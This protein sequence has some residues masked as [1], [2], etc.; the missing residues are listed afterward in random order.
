MKPVLATELDPR[1]RFAVT[2][3]PLL[4]EVGAGLFRSFVLTTGSCFLPSSIDILPS[5]ISNPA[6]T[7][8]TVPCRSFDTTLLV[9]LQPKTPTSSFT[10]QSHHVHKNQNL[11]LGVH[12]WSE[13]S[14]LRTLRRRIALCLRID[15]KRLSW[16]VCCWIKAQ[17]VNF[18]HCKENKIAFWN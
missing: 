18:H 8:I 7:R 11:L 14:L 12:F 10:V 17:K 5:E 3:L 9:Q 4:W 15:S 2:P 13:V 6:D 16:L 1:P